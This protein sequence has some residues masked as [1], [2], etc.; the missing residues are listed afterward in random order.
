VVNRVLDWI[1]GLGGAVL[2]PVIG[3][4]AF[5]E[6]AALV[7]LF[8]PG[9]AGMVVAGAAVKRAGLSLPIA[10]AIA[11]VGATAGDSISYSVGRR[12]GLRAIDRY[13]LTRRHL[14]K[15]I[16]PARRH[17]ERH[18]VVTVFVSR[19]VGALRAVA[20]LIAGTAEMHYPRFFIAN[21]LG[22]LTWSATVLTVGY[23]FGDPIAD[24]VDRFALWLSVAVA[25]IAAAFF[26]F[27]WWRGR[28]RK[29]ETV[30][31]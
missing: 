10:I 17:F 3:L 14:G 22:A 23:V 1:A 4:L 26:G 24:L 12:W 15:H 16:E 27:R 2:Y 28:H 5:G 19:W 29:D 9:E 31:S 13:E 25:V 21:F 6:S 30:S 20:P 11:T 7:D 8:V 18:G